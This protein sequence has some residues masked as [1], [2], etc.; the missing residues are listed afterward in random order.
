MIALRNRFPMQLATGS[1]V[2]NREALPAPA[3]RVPVRLR[4]D[5]CDRE[6][7]LGENFRAPFWRGQ[8]L[9]AKC[10]PPRSPA[11]A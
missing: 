6:F 1:N 4:C 3:P 9:C 10:R 8:Q 11:G 5:H 7:Y 2:F